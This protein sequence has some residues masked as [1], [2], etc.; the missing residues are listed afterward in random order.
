MTFH[1]CTPIY[2]SS[3]REHSDAITH[4]PTNLEEY[5]FVCKR[6][7]FA[8]NYRR[9]SSSLLKPYTKQ[10]AFKVCFL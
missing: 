1:F 8:R 10:H 4:L 3:Q 5:S 2:S 6:W 7:L 9:R